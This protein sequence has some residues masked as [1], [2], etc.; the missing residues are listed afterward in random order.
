MAFKFGDLIKN[1]S[2]DYPGRYLFLANVKCEQSGHLSYLV[3]CLH[4]G[5]SIALVDDMEPWFSPIPDGTASASEIK[6]LQNKAT[7]QGEISLAQAQSLL[8]RG[9]L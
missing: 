2:L 3:M 7:F 4:Y 5:R 8:Q 6:W 1:K 9:S